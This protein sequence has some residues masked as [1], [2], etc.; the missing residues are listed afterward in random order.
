MLRYEVS[1]LYADKIKLVLNQ[2]RKGNINYNNKVVDGL[3]IIDVEE[4]GAYRF[5]TLCVNSRIPFEKYLIV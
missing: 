5:E 3:F 1:I 2:L 4:N